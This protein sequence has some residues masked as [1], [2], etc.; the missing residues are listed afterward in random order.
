MLAK[1]H[2]RTAGSVLVASRS[3]VYVSGRSQCAYLWLE[4]TVIAEK[5]IGKKEFH[6]SSTSVA[7]NVEPE[8]MGLQSVDCSCVSV[9]LLQLTPPLVISLVVS[10]T[11]TSLGS[12]NPLV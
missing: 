12:K 5:L 1:Q 10:N 7:S 3:I 6:T 8:M 9:Q 11:T 4:R 2:L